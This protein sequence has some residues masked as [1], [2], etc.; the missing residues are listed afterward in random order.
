MARMDSTERREV[1]GAYAWVQPSDLAAAAFSAA[2][3]TEK[4]RCP[5]GRRILDLSYRPVMSC[6]FHERDLHSELAWMWDWKPE[7]RVAKVGPCSS[8]RSGHQSLKKNWSWLGKAKFHQIT[9]GIRS[10]TEVESAFPA[11]IPSSSSLEVK[12]YWHWW[13]YVSKVRTYY[14]M[15]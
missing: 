15:V 10:S 9:H 8:G 3:P 11:R 1:C 12:V 5:E 2:R 14:R 13:R 7:R 4:Q 6:P